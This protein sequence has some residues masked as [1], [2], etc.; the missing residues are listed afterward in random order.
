MYFIFQNPATSG[1]FYCNAVQV[2]LSEGI[3]VM[4]IMKTFH[5]KKEHREAAFDHH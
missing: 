3:Q 1:K 5:A 4:N 2:A